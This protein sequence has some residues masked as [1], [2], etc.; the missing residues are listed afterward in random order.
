MTRRP[1]TFRQADI[2]RA[3]RAVQM[4]GLSVAVVRINPQGQIEIVAGRVEGQDSQPP[5]ELDR[6]LAAFEA[7][8]GQG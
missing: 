7:R 6:E 5:D 2:R 1:C 8:H 3:I 4:A